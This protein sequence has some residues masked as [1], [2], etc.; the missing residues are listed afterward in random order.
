[1]TLKRRSGW[2]PAPGSESIEVVDLGEPRYLTAV[3]P[4]KSTVCLVP[5]DEAAITD[6]GEPLTAEQTNASRAQ[7][8]R[9][10]PLIPAS[11]EVAAL[12]RGARE[13]FAAR[14]AARVAPL[15]AGAT[16]PKAAATLLLAAATVGTPIRRQLLCIRRDF[17]CIAHLAKKHSWTVD[18]PVPSDAF[19]PMWPANLVP[20]WVAE[21][22]VPPA[23][24]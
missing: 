20:E 17:D 5:A 19:G 22:P 7:H 4:A 23:V 21:P 14:C 18:T 2:E 24:G 13:A 9:N 3:G 8:N 1:M 16:S 12:P 11:E 10:R 15:R 6:L